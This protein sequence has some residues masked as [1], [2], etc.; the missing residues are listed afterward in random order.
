MKPTYKRLLLLFAAVLVTVTL[1]SAAG[2][3]STNLKVKRVWIYPYQTQ[4]SG[5]FENAMIIEK[6]VTVIKF[7]VD[8]RVIEHCGHYTVE[9]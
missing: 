7:K 4:T 8:D 3:S 6:T 1:L 5:L 9:N 2:S